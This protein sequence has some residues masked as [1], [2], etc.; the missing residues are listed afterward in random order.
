MTSSVLTSGRRLESFRLRIFNQNRASNIQRDSSIG[1]KRDSKYNTH[2]F[3]KHNVDKNTNVQM[4]DFSINN[5]KS[6]LKQRPTDSVAIQQVVCM[7]GW[8]EG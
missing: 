6:W 8:F 2:V 1:L 5:Q 4:V 3:R 7:A